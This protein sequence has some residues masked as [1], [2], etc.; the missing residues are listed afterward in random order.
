[1]NKVKQTKTTLDSIKEFTNIL[2]DGNNCQYI[3]LSDLEYVELILELL[4]TL[5][6]DNIHLYNKELLKMA[7][8]SLP[9]I[10]LEELLIPGHR[11]G[12]EA[13]ECIPNNFYIDYSYHVK[14][15]KHLFILEV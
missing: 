10:E 9:Y 15:G 8:C 7:K 4:P 2:I 14:E 13:I 6:Q 11:I 5:K 1:M 3:L 12:I